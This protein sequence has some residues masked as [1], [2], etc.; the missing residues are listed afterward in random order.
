MRFSAPTSPNSGT[1]VFANATFETAAANNR[2]TPPLQDSATPNQAIA[3]FQRVP[4]IDL[5]GA[6]ST[7]MYAPDFDPGSDGA[8]SDAAAVIGPLTLTGNSLM[9]FDHFFFTEGGF[10]GGV[11]KFRRSPIFNAYRSP[12]C[13]ALRPG[14]HL[15]KRLK[16]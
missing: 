9:E 7:G 8:P 10:D 4:N 5:G 13:D 1:P 15:S 16:R 11:M 12:T 2:F 14:H 3:A 6:S